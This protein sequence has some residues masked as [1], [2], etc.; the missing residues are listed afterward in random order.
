MQSEMMKRLF[1]LERQWPITTEAHQR[2]RQD[3]G[4][5]G[6]EGPEKCLQMQTIIQQEKETLTWSK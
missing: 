4:I 6:E 2:H 5:E 3:V 1:A